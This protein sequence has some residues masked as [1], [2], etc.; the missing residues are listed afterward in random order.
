MNAQDFAEKLA[1]VKNETQL[2]SL[3]T[4]MLS[5]PVSDVPSWIGLNGDALIETY[6]MRF[7]DRVHEAKKYWRDSFLSLADD[8]TAPAVQDVEREK[9]W[10]DLANTI[11]AGM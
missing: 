7:I 1:S 10:R 8:M 6:P 5:N 2:E 3:G 4:E 11:T 9:F